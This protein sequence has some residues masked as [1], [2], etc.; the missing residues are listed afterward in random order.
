MPE[1]SAFVFHCNFY[2]KPKVDLEDAEIKPKIK[3][4]LTDLQQRYD[5]Q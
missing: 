1:K 3:Q 2:P 5:Y 4:K